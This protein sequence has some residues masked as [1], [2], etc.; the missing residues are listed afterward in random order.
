M[1]CWSIRKI[2]RDALKAVDPFYLISSQLKIEKNFLHIKNQVFDLN[3]FDN[4]HVLGAGKGAVSLFKGLETVMGDRISGGII[5]SVK[6]QAFYHPTVKFYPGS[7]PVPSPQS[8]CAGE[9]VTDYIKNKVGPKDLIIFLVTG[10]ASSLMAVPLPPVKLE[11]KIEITKLL[12][13]SGASINEINCTRKHLSTLKGGRLAEMIYP[14]KVISLILSDI[15]DSS[16]ENIGSGPTVGDSTSFHDVREI[17][18]RY[19][20]DKNVPPRILKLI[21]DGIKKEITDTPLPESKIFL[22]NAHFLLGD[23]LTALKAARKSA[24]AQGV[25]A[26]IITS[27]DKG[28]ASE[29]A[30]VYAAIVREII[31]SGNPF[32]SPVLLLSGGELTV[33]LKGHGKGGRNQEFVLALLYELEEI[34]QPF[35]ILSMG[36]DGIDGPTDAAGA[37]I[38]QFT[39]K[40]VKDQNLDIKKYLK[41]NNSYEFFNAIDQLIKTGPTGTNVMDLRMFYL[42]GISRAQSA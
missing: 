1:K 30:G 8:L 38:D 33:T 35:F 37:W 13:A 36:T 14:A 41:E 40:K 29:A 18:Y 26:Y 6:T 12:L 5:I 19:K 9:A 34:G 15:I 21:E 23:N 25:P 4:I 31:L 2:I 27:S 24:E 16:L 22:Q 39:I 20:L 28:E 7:H 3:H 42:P 17:F 11:D 10:G 32:Q